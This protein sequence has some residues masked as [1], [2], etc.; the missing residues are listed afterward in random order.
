MNTAVVI[1]EVGKA[2]LLSASGFG[3]ASKRI[4]IAY[5]L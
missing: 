5:G 1:D 4:V 2:T 3:R